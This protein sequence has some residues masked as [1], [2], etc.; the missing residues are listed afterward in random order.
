MKMIIEMSQMEN[1][2]LESTAWGSHEQ[3][4]SNGSGS[5]NGCCIFTCQSRIVSNEKIRI[6]HNV[7]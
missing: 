7:D 4:M 2:N 5:W 1:N 3:V 6:K